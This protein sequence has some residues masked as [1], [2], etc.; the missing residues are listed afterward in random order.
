MTEHKPP[1]N[2]GL[3][4]PIDSGRGNIVSDA[5]YKLV[6]V[7]TRTPL[8]QRHTLDQSVGFGTGSNEYH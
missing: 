8:I 1:K 2:K 5:L 4:T 3:E 7:V 6:V